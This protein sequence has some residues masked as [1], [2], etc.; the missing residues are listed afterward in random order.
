MRWE[1]PQQPGDSEKK[2]GFKKG[3]D[4]G[5]KKSGENCGGPTSSAALPCCGE[6]DALQKISLWFNR[7]FI[8][9]SL[10]TQATLKQENIQGSVGQHAEISRAGFSGGAER[11]T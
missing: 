1:R 10:W 3:M 7:L 8:S 6:N 4:E 5:G 2:M 9:E 11:P